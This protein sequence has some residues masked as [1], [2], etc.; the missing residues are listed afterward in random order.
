MTAYPVHYRVEHPRA[1]AP[2]QLLIRFVAFCALGI[3]G[4]SFGS[5]F[6]FA[7]LF[8]PVVAA[9]RT[10][11]REGTA[12]TSQDGPR[13]VRALGWFAAVSAWAGLISDR[14]PTRTPDEITVIEVEGTTHPT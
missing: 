9:V 8:L 1:F 13:I 10:T 2:L 7:Y 11:S 12:Y 3:F 14:L 4:I 6:L 5:V